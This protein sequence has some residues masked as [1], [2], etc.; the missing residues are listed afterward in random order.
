MTEWL[1]GDNNFM[2]RWWDAW[3][4]DMEI[5]YKSSEK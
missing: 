4:C 1:N 3:I 5:L 2:I